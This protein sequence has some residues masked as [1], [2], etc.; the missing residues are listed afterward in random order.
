MLE[1]CDC[2]TAA[3]A[4][5]EEGVATGGREGTDNC[6]G[7][8]TVLRGGKAKENWREGG[9]RIRDIYETIMG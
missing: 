6:G 7:N 5:E 9:V 2:D 8:E 4:V 3:V 1:R